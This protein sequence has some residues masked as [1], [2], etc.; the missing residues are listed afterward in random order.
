[1]LCMYI[2]VNGVVQSMSASGLFPSE[3]ARYTDA[4][5]ITYWTTDSNALRDAHKLAGI[6]LRYSDGSLV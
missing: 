4:G 2:V 1:M 3:L 5:W 6:P